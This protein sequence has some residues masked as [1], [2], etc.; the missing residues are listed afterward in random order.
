M[1]KKIP[2]QS[3]TSVHEVAPKELARGERPAL[4]DNRSLAGQEVA[5]YVPAQNFNLSGAEHSPE[6]V[7]TTSSNESFDNLSENIDLSDLPDLTGVQLDDWQTEVADNFVAS[8]ESFD[9]NQP[10][11]LDNKLQLENQEQFSKQPTTIHIIDGEKGGCG[12]SFFCRTF[13]EYCLSINYPVTVVD[14]DTSNEDIIKIYPDVKVAFFSD[15]EKQAKQAD[16][17]FDFAFEKSVIVNLPAQV[18]TNVTQWIQG[19]N[20]I[21][22]GKE[23]SIHFVK[24]FVCTGGLDSVNFFL[25]S[26]DDLGQTMTHVFV[27]N[28]GLCDDWKYVEE[29]PQFNAA[30]NKYDFIVVDFPKFPFWERNMIDRLETTFSHALTHPEFKVI[31]K[32]RVKNFLKQAYT[33]ISVT[34]LIS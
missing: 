15:D 16:N 10:E 18:Y 27:R 28:F 29:M 31:S 6:V 32:Q 13:I 12:K 25:K 23:N 24:W 2:S 30:K 20:L 7:N 34:G 8:D 21:D 3:K 9:S 11:N 26:L 33:N 1:P 17:I 22:L 19:N 14:A 4:H 5:P